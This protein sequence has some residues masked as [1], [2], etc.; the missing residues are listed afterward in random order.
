M[1]SIESM[2]AQGKAGQPVDLPIAQG[3]AAGYSWQ[4]DLPAGVVRLEDGPQRTAAPGQ[5][6]GAATG[7][8][9]RVQAPKGQYTIMAR[10]ARPWGGDAVRTVSIEL[11]VD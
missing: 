11:T 10:L 5:R 7:G 1:A 4:L 6:L 2:K 3:P 9:L 8:A